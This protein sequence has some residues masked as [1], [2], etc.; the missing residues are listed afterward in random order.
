MPGGCLGGGGGGMLKL[1]FNRYINGVNFEFLGE[2]ASC[3]YV[4]MK[5]RI[6]YEEI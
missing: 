3:M 1:Q 4:A 6:A 2:T 5:F